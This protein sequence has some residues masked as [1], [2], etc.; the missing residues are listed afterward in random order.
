[1]SEVQEDGWTEDMRLVRWLEAWFMVVG[2][3][4]DLKP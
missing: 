2:S 1:M 4:V 3:I